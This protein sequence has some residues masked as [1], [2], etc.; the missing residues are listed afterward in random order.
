MERFR[1]Y[2]ILQFSLRS[3]F[4][5]APW[6]NNFYIV[7]NGQV[8]V[9]LDTTHPRVHIVTHAEIF[10]HK[11]DL[12]TFNSNAIELN[13][14]RIAGLSEC[15]FYLN[16]DFFV[17]QPVTKD[18]YVDQ[19]HKRINLYIDG[20]TAPE[21]KEMQNNIWHE[22]VGRTNRMISKYYYPGKI[23]KKHHY[24][25]HHCYFFDKNILRLVGD[26]YTKQIDKTTASKFR[27]E[28]DVTVPILH[29]STALEEFGA[30]IYR[31]HF[32]FLAWSED[33]ERN[34]ASWNSLLGQESPCSC[35]N[36]EIDPS[37]E[38]ESEFE[39][40]RGKMCTIFPDPS[41]LEKSGFDICA[42]VGNVTVAE[43]PGLAVKPEHAERFDRAFVRDDELGG[44]DSI[45]FRK[46]KANVDA[47]YFWNE[48]SE[49]TVSKGALQLF[50]RSAEKYIKHL[51]NVI[52]LT[53]NKVPDF[54]KQ[55]VKNLH[56][57]RLSQFV[58][59]KILPT[60]NIN[61]IVSSLHQLPGIV[62]SCFTFSYDGFIFNHE[63]LM[64]SYF[65]AVP[66]QNFKT[67][68]LGD[69]SP[70]LRLVAESFPMVSAR[71]AQEQPFFFEKSVLKQISMF[72]P[73]E[74]HAAASHSIREAS[75]FD[76]GLAFSNIVANFK[77]R[78]KEFVQPAL[79]RTK[80]DISKW[81]H[82]FT[83]PSGFELPD[84]NVCN[85]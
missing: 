22:S 7:T 10:K 61:A 17:S 37:P 39:N 54:L 32:A 47:I 8:P 80:D 13:L 73:E 29:A 70:T 3:F 67:E 30:N 46:C 1:D 41:P 9:W 83:V 34:E 31:K 77:E 65:Q 57:I 78:R 53:N 69:D 43:T 12:P 74:T 81:C 26:R 25:G 50:L 52:V 51:G 64:K 60:T 55:D 33:H 68:P 56:I 19:E 58:D 63:V 14:H 59:H 48:Y 28:N 66:P 82:V 45:Q 27:S 38:G 40:L 24:A 16:D 42:T 49:E 5:Y 71:Y 20:Y 23:V 4:K 72:W 84:T 6:V 62:S 11:G 18:F 21:T 2:G 36:D 44:L 85:L 35:I 76:T 15:F 79:V 75:D